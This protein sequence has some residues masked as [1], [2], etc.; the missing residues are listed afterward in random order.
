[1]T[2]SFLVGIGLGSAHLG[3]LLALPV[4]VAAVLMKGLSEVLIPRNWFTGGPSQYSI[5]LGELAKRGT[6]PD[7]PWLTYL[8]QSSGIRL[9]SRRGRFCTCALSVLGH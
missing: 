8:V 2:F 9:A 7:H 5:Y 3:P 1:M 4:L 6:V